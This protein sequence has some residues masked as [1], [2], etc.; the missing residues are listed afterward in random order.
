MEG[1]KVAIILFGLSR[2][3]N[4]TID[5]LRM[6][7]FAPL[8]EN[9]IEYDVFVHTYKIFGPYSNIW[10]KEFTD[11]YENEDIEGLLNPKYYIFDEQEKIQNSINFEEYYTNL[12]NWS[13]TWMGE[14]E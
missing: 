5:S 10:S 7:L 14:T 11:N 4:K 3:L 8:T 9:G 1:K 2:S 13:L 12:G 6:N